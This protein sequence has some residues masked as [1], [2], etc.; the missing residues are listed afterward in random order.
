MKTIA[1]AGND[2][3][4]ETITISVYVGNEQ[5]PFVEKKILNEKKAVEKFYKRLA[6]EHKILACYEASGNGYV[7]YRWLKDMGIAC[8]IIAPSLI[9]KKKGDRIKTDKRDARKLARYYR[10]G[11][12]TTI[13]V[14]DE[15]E[16]SIRSLVRLREQVSKDVRNSKQY[17]L[18]FLQV[19]GLVY[20]EG[21]NWTQK[22][23]RYLKGIKFEDAVAHRV[24]DEYIM[25]LEYKEEFLK[26]VD[27]DIFEIA[28]GEE[29]CERVERLM[30][31]RGV[32][33]TTAM[34]VIT[35]VVDFKRFAKPRELMAYLG[36]IPS[37]RSS[38]EERRQ[39]GITKTGNKRVRRLLVEAS[40]HYRH[41]PRVGKRTTGEMEEAW[42]IAH[43]AQ[44]RL[45]VK[46]WRMVN[47]GKCKTKAV[48]AVARELAGF[49]WA[50][51]QAA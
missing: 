44:R 47:R 20:K 3:H 13:H 40:W 16:E 22:H 24:F 35:E 43:K 2:V 4:Q 31:L 45:Y 11:E 33:E 5:E 32:R 27:A 1:Y 23:R 37:E 41:R 8:E 6:R 39:S 29:Y 38:G 26:K 10:S 42:M 15:E 50:I 34:G 36:L 17:L 9:P 12:L 49:I 21:T 30:I 7:F 48:T 14:P 46:Y 28:H 19:R 18:K 25:M 51:M